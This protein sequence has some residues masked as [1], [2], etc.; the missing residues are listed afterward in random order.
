MDTTIITEEDLMQFTG[1]EN[2]YRHWLG[3]LYTDGVKFVAERANAYWLIDAIISY[4]AGSIYDMPFQV[5]TLTVDR[6]NKTAVLQ[7]RQD[8]GRCVEVRQEIPYT[9]FP[10]AEIEMYFQN[11][12]LFLPSEY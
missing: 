1:T 4:Q 6:E 11:G 12:V 5:W 7:M 2:Y 3:K 10:L 8:S 9:D